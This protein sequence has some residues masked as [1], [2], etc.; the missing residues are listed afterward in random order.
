MGK[1][2]G[3]GFREKTRGSFLDMLAWKCRGHTRIQALGLRG[4]VVAEK[5]KLESRQFIDGI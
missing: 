4:D 2:E 1:L 5:R 3:M